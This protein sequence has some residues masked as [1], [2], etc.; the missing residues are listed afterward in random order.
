M[1]ASPTGTLAPNLHPPSR[2]PFCERKGNTR[3]RFAVNFNVS[4]PGHP[5][6]I[7]VD[8]FSSPGRGNAAIS[9]KTPTTFWP[10]TPF[11]E[12]NLAFA[13]DEFSPTGMLVFIEHTGGGKVVGRNSKILSVGTK[14]GRESGW[15]FC[16]KTPQNRHCQRK[17]KT[18]VNFNVARI[19]Q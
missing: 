14:T 6:H 8:T 19:A 2:A 16:T 17:Y 7:K 9:A 11:H 18:T 3:S 1:F 4:H 12:R 15:G 13:T 10:P 5:R